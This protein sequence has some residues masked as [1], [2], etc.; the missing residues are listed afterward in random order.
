MDPN[1][2]NH[3]MKKQQILS[4]SHPISEKSTV[5]PDTRFRRN[6]EEDSDIP[7]MLE[8]VPAYEFDDCNEFG[9][10]GLWTLTRHPY[11]RLSFS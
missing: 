3:P 4:Q 6:Y 7:E 8:D 9:A 5:K 2:R 11:W 1:L 10:D